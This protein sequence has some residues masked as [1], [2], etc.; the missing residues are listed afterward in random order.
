MAEVFGHG[1]EG[2]GR[3]GVEFAFCIEEAIGC[4]DVDVGVEEEVV[5]KG[6]DGGC[7]GDAALGEV[8]PGA[9]GVAQGVDGRLEE[10][11]EEVAAFAEDAAE[12]FWDGEDVLAVGDGLADGGGDPG[13]DLQGA[14][15]VAGGTEV[16]G[17]AG[18]GKEVL[19]AAVG[20]VVASEAGGDVATAK[21]LLDVGDGFWAQGAHG[22][23]VVGFVAGNELVP[24][25]VD[26]LPEG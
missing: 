14:A 17:F 1:A 19:V 15:L 23:A 25:V 21:E 16:A 2:V 9:E 3:H 8:E 10:M 18:E 24:G 11:V 5:A 12:D 26:E 13:A 6:V 4:E 22:G 7:G 20:A